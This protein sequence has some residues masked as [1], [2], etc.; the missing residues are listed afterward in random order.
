LYTA[1]GYEPNSPSTGFK[2]IPK[3]WKISG[4]TVTSLDLDTTN[5]YARAIVLAWK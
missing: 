3:V 5:A 4:G 2:Y 1:A